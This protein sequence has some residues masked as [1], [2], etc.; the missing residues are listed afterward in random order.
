M[1]R[2][3][4][5][6]RKIT[7][8]RA[9]IGADVAQHIDQLKGHAVALAESQHLVLAQAGE[10]PDM[11]ETEPRPKFT[12]T[13]GNQIRVFI[14]IGSGAECAN[15]LRIVESL[16]I[17]HLAPRDFAEHDANVVAIGM[18][19]LVQPIKAIRQRLEQSLFVLVHL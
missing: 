14:Q 17:E 10:I 7:S 15:F 3:Q 1:R 8:A 18:L 6:F 4:F 19:D 12:D 9:K 16:Q 13:T 2:S 5:E 11:P